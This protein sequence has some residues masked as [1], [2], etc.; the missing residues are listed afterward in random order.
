MSNFFLRI[1]V[2]VSSQIHRNHRWCWINSIDKNFT[3]LMDNFNTARCRGFYW[4]ICENSFSDPAIRSKSSANLKLL[5]FRP[6]IVILDVWSARES[7]IMLSRNMLNRTGDS[8]QPYLITIVPLKLF[9]IWLFNSTELLVDL[10]ID[11]MIF[12]RWHCLWHI[13]L[14]TSHV[15]NPITCHTLSKAFLKSMKLW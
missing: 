13:Q 1:S 8:R 15:I 12:T 14:I 11:F 10:Y 7:C 5:I 4:R 3:F 6:P 2:P 9:P